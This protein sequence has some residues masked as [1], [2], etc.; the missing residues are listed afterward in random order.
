LMAVGSGFTSPKTVSFSS[1]YSSYKHH[2]AY[3]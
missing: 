2:T 1:E 3:T